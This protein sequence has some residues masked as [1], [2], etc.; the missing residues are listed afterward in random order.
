[1]QSNILGVFII[2]SFAIFGK[3]LEDRIRIR[4][5]GTVREMYTYFN[6]HLSLSLGMLGL[7]WA[8]K[9]RAQTILILIFIIIAGIVSKAVFSGNSPERLSPLDWDAFW[10]LCVPNSFG[11]ASVVFYF[12]IIQN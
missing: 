3:M 4:S 11:I 7:F 8:S 12:F 2:A 9:V 5:S 1:M 6:F 10:G